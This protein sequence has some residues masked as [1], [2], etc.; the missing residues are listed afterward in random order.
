MAPVLRAGFKID[1]FNRDYTGII[2]QVTEVA[3][4]DFDIGFTPNV[5]TKDS[6][7]S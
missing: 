3:K 7:S 5:I 4:L 2:S 1:K 6:A